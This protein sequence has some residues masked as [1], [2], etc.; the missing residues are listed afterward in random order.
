MADSATGHVLIESFEPATSSGLLSRL[1]QRLSKSEEEP[2]CELL[3]VRTTPEGV[4]D[5]RIIRD[6]KAEA[7]AAKKETMAFY[8][9]TTE[10]LPVETT[11]DDLTTA[12]GFGAQMGMAGFWTVADSRQFLEE[13]GLGKVTPGRP[14]SSDD[15]LRWIGATVKSRIADEIAR[16]T[17][18]DLRDR[19]A[20]PAGW[21]EKQ[22]QPVCKACGVVVK[23]SGVTWESQAAER[24]AQQKQDIEEESHKT[25]L[26]RKKA[27]QEEQRSQQVL[28]QVAVKKAHVDLEH[29]A[30]DIRK[31]HAEAELRETEARLLVE[32]SS[33]EREYLQSKMAAE[34]ACVEQQDK[35][36]HAFLEKSAIEREFMAEMKG[37]VLDM[38][39]QREDVQQ[40]ELDLSVSWRAF[41]APESWQTSAPLKIKKE[42]LA[43]CEDLSSGE[44]LQVFVETSHDAFVYVLT[45]GPYLE[46][47][48]MRYQW[49][50]LF[51]NGATDDAGYP[52]S[53]ADGNLVRA[54]ERLCLPAGA[55]TGSD[56]AS[57]V[58]TLDNNHDAVE[59]FYVLASREP[60]AD[61]TIRQL[62]DPVAT[63]GIKK[64]SGPPPIPNQ[65]TVAGTAH[66]GDRFRKYVMQ[67][68]GPSV[69]VT[70]HRFFHFRASI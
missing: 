39:R 35:L 52:L 68:L 8:R 1:A 64:Y 69:K 62:I 65:G 18:E 7:K 33:V 12:D 30:A 22:V 28:H 43:S 37:I 31:T 16:Q 44:S 61:D 41:E 32:N 3:S 45:L 34:K 51:S 53:R 36:V 15:F 23:L 11:V 5:I 25:E 70:E 54:G 67:K 4:A 42:S 50:R 66:D 63:R 14:L 13:Q 55:V 2:K 38:A 40:G 20:L 47:S 58:W 27:E 17:F 57:R 60:I 29:E 24:V 19:D 48:E 26:E 9:V 49:Y 46:G 56:P 59:T 21:I 10:S 6:L